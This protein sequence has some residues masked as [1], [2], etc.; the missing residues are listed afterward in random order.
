MTSPTAHDPTRALPHHRSA[1]E[2]IGPDESI[3]EIPLECLITVEMGKATDIG[4]AVLQSDLDLD[5][6]KHVFLMLFMVRYR[7]IRNVGYKCKTFT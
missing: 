2:E 3:I 4:R 7:V 1:A 5:A 6:P